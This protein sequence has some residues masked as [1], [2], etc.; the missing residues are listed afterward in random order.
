MD[1]SGSRIVAAIAVGAALL[2]GA[3]I[4]RSALER[5]TAALGELQTAVADLGKAF[6]EGAGARAF[7]PARAD[8]PA[9]PDPGA[10]Y[11]VKT[12]GAPVRGPANAKITLVEFLDFQ[13][14]FCS[15]VQPTLAQIQKTYGDKVRIVFKH[16][17]LRIHAQAPGAAAAAEA[18]H[19]QDKFW[20]MHDL[21]FANQR[22][23]GDAKYQ[24]WARQLGLDMDRFQKDLK[25]PAVGQ[26]I[27]ADS[28]EAAKLGVSGTPAFFI[29]GRYVSGA[30]PFDAFKKVIDEE[31]TKG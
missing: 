12:D 19:S 11:A 2:V 13:C 8:Q 17:P 6:R 26:R 15:R 28:Q 21:M 14:P 7:P 25:S 10:H 29:N 30:Q 22:D 18:A 27:E 16:L 1:G 23:L 24:E 20:E 3:L 31:L 4:V 9:S 5:Q